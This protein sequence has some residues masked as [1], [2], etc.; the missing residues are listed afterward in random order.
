M[1]LEQVSVKVAS[2]LVLD[3]VTLELERGESAL[4]LGRNGAGKSTLLKALMGI[5]SICRGRLTL[6]GIDLTDSSIQQR[7]FHGISLVPEGRRIFRDH[8][9]RENLQLGQMGARITHEELFWE[10][11]EFVYSLFPI[12]AKRAEQIAGTLSGGEQQMLSIGRAIVGKPRVLLLDEPSIGLAPAVLHQLYA[13]ISQLSDL[14][15]SMIAAEQ[16]RQ[17][18]ESICDKIIRL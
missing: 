4:V 6:A 14:G 17:P 7:Y 2:S 1:T 13:S 10:P 3:D 5:F 8:T 15:I 9:V 16:R 12:L 18:A 11:L